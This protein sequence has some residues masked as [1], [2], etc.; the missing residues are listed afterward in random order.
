MAEQETAT[1]VQEESY[2][3]NVTVED[4]GPGTKKVSVQ[5]PEDRIKTVL[6]DQFKDLKREAA[7][8]GFRAGR[9]PRKLVEK[10]FAPDVREQVRRQ[11]LSESYEQALEKNNLQ[12]IGEPEFDNPDDIKLPESGAFN[13]SFSIEVQPDIQLPDF[14]QLTVKKPKIEVTEENVEQAMKNLREQQGTLVP[15]EDRGA[16]DGDYVTADVSVKLGDEQILH[17]P[18]AQLVA[19]A[20]RIG[21]IQVEDFADKI[22]GAKADEARTF[23]LHAPETHS[24]ER[25]RDKDVEVE[26]KVKG[27]KKLEPAVIDEVFLE[28]FGFADEQELRGALREQLD[29][30][31]KG[32]VQN[33][34]R[35]QVND[36][37]VTNVQMEL[38]AKLTERQADRIIQRRTIDL[39]M[40]GMPREQIEQN[41]EQI[42]SGAGDEAQRELKL[43]FILQKVATEQQVDVDEAELN[44]QIAMMAAQRGRRP[45]KLKQEMAA[46]GSLSN[47]YVQLREQRALDKI[48]EQ[49]TIEEVDPPAAET[50]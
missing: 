35:Q 50:K 34:M 41:I 42:R 11:L 40:R 49:A 13:Y 24:D 9:A 23:T 20:G 17:Q 44:G 14:S 38:P 16:E 48:I 30:R 15:V 31:I 43:F 7:I 45:E 37:L 32:D 12:V 2:T 19:R 47:M 33:H 1:D 8:P 39:M 27:L 26:V 25:I 28:S 46:D 36:F 18:D 29:E 5:I 4:A 22:R 6:D 3:Y 21:G 10:R